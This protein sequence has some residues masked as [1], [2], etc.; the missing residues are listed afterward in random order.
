VAEPELSESEL[1]AAVEIAREVV[2]AERDEEPF[3]LN[4]IRS[5]ETKET[6]VMMA[7]AIVELNRRWE[8]TPWQE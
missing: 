5:D 7:K 2:R 4:G 3:Y 6:V 8:S 1:V